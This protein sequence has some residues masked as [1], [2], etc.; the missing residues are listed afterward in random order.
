MND[1]E[2]IVLYLVGMMMFHAN[3]RTDYTDT[4][5]L[6]SHPI[7]MGYRNAVL[8]SMEFVAWDFPD[9]LT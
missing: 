9:C 7:Y 8:E 2:T 4:R 6:W 5:L 1:D 3:D